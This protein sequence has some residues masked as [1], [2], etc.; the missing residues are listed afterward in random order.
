MFQSFFL[1]LFSEAW[2]EGGP[3]SQLVRQSGSNSQVIGTS[4]INFMI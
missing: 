3:E 2:G 1:L 4:Q